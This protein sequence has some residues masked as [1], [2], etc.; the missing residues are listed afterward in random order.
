MAGFTAVLDACVLY[1]APMKDIL[2]SLA[3]A[4][5][6]R[7]KWSDQIHEE[8]ISSLLRNRSDL[9]REQLEKTRQQMNKIPDSLVVGYENLIDS[10]TLR[11]PDDRHVLAV[12]IRSWADSI[13][14]LNLRDFDKSE[15][16]K[17]DVVAEHPDEFICNMIELAQPR[18]LSAVK[19]MRVRL[20]N[21][22]KTVEELLDK[23]A[24]SGL[25][26][27]AQYLADFSD[28]L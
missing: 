21:P 15:L 18:V 13:V 10:L 17:Y 3:H 19:Q 16:A 27:T 26:Q 4:G 6:Y 11:D 20:R 5:I 23:L 25:T 7:A 14:T 9:T 22:P 12:A 24:E 2:L 8:W 28:V 1:P